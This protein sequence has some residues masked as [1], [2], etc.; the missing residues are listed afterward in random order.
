MNT[1]KTKIFIE[2]ARRIH[3][4]KY[5][6]SK[7]DYVKNSI[8]VCIICPEHGEFWQTPNDH[9]D[10]HGCPK[11]KAQKSS[12]CLRMTLEQFIE[13]ARKVH[14]DKYDYSKVEYVNNETKV[15]IICHEKDENGIEH[16][17]FWQTP[18]LHLRGRGCRKCA[19]E[20]QIKRTKLTTEEFIER[21]RKVHGDKYDYSK[22]KY[23]NINA[24]IC[25][26]CH[27]K[28]EFGN[29]HGEFWQYAEDH[30]NGFGCRKCSKMYMDTQTFIRRSQKVHG[31][32]Y[33]YSKAQYINRYTKVCIICPEH[34]EF[35]Q[36]VNHHMNGHGCPKCKQSNLEKEIIELLDENNI[37]YQYNERYKFVNNLQLDFYIPDLK[38]AI[39]CQ[40][41]QHF[42]PVEHWGGKKTYERVKF[43]DKQK[44]KLCK[45][46]NVKL[47]YYSNLKIKYPYEVIENKEKILEIIKNE[48]EQRRNIIL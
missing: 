3:G 47:I 39:E 8:K 35:W 24:K 46:N 12:N 2:K 5:D 21:A 6:Y 40:G 36:D 9:L 14:G 29:E 34:G 48:T 42:K 23:T 19:I 44:K 13:K 37:A 38:I 41:E 16:G 7:V 30:L 26:I 20:K 31:D 1:E 22:V 11:C 17:E 4:E 43:N 28:D 18:H 27:E 32:K 10:N 25:I 15:C 45:K 33:D